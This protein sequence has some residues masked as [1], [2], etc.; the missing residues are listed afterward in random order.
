MASSSMN[1]Q[2]TKSNRLNT[3]NAAAPDAGE[4]RKLN[5]LVNTLT[6]SIMPTIMAN[7]DRPPTIEMSFFAIGRA[8]TA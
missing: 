3:V 8:N 6:H 4:A 2:V 5:M 7:T 1:T